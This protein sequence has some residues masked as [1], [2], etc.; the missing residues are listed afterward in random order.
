MN[1]IKPYIQIYIGI[2]NFFKAFS[3]T[4]KEKEDYKSSIFTFS[5]ILL[6]DFIGLFSIC[7][8]PE[9]IPVDPMY[10]FVLIGIIILALN[11]YI[12]IKNK[13]IIVKIESDKNSKLLWIFIIVSIL[14]SMW[15][16]WLLIM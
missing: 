7:G 5:F 11:Y 1:L 8:I 14:L 3:I 9:L 2:H 6:S 10:Q 15:P 12:I 13:K 16:W 4:E